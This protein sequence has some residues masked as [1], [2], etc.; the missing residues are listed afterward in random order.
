[1]GVW[2]GSGRKK[3]GVAVAIWAMEVNWAELGVENCTQLVGV[4]PNPLAIKVMSS[5]YS[6]ALLHAGSSLLDTFS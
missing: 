4:G 6:I 5:T 1:M 2:V 3:V